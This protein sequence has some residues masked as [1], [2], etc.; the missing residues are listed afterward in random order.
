MQNDGSEQNIRDDNEVNKS[1]CQARRFIE[2]AAGGPRSF[3]GEA[4]RLV[5]AAALTTRSAVM[6][7]VNLLQGNEAYHLPEAKSLPPTAQAWQSR[8]SRYP[9]YSEAEHLH[10]M[11]L[12]GKME[13][14]GANLRTKV[15]YSCAEAGRRQEPGYC[16]QRYDWDRTRQSRNTIG[17][18]N[19]VSDSPFQRTT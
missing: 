11:A 1:W 9:L 16:R 7:T 3:T 15:L 12:R 4:Q 5:R 13:D 18:I 14:A 19:T 6:S 2:Y 8:A 10:R 17:L